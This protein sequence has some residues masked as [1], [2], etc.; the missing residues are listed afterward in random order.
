MSLDFLGVP[1]ESGVL[2]PLLQRPE[3]A[4]PLLLR[5]ALLA[6]GVASGAAHARGPPL[7]LPSSSSAE[8]SNISLS[9]PS[10]TAGGGLVAA[11]GGEHDASGGGE[12]STAAASGGGEASPAAMMATALARAVREKAANMNSQQLATVAVALVKLGCGDARTADRVKAGGALGGS[13]DDSKATM[14]AIAKASR[15]RMHEFNAQV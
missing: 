4:L 14:V 15:R 12:C 8:D 7:V 9:L 6:V 13:E 11:S 10:P 5:L 2:L 1:D 3:L